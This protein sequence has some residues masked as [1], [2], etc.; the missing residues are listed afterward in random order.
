ME[1]FSEEEMKPLSKTEIA[2]VRKS[3]KRD[4]VT[5]AV[6]VVLG[7]MALWV[8]AIAGAYFAGKNF[9]LE[10]FSK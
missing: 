1:E 5:E 8:T 2:R 10:L 9:I 7:K 3:L 4:A 6:F